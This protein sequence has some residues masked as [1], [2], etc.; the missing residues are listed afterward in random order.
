MVGILAIVDPITGLPLYQ[1]S[2]VNHSENFLNPADPNI[3]TQM[4]E[5]NWCRAK[6][7]NKRRCGTRRSMVDGYLCKFMW[8][9]RLAGRNSFDVIW[10][11]IVQFMPP[12]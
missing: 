9:K 4:I 8:R 6:A 7:A 5:S 3:N 10:E 2:T 1:H 12:E 11:S